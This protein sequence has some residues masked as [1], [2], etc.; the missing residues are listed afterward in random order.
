MRRRNQMTRIRKLLYQSD[1][2]CW[3]CGVRLRMKDVTQDHVVPRADGGTSR[4]SNIV[5]ACRSCNAAKGDMSLEEYRERVCRGD[6]F[7]GELV[8]MREPERRLA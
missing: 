4:R 6:W 3:Y 1:G 7:W 5:A 8:L 2:R